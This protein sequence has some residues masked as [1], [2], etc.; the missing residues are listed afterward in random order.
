MSD[1][2]EIQ[3]SVVTK[4]Q[5]DFWPV[6]VHLVDGRAL[7]GRRVDV[8]PTLPG[9]IVLEGE[10]TFDTEKYF[11]VPYPQRAIIAITERRVDINLRHVVLIDEGIS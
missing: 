4:S 7:I 9:W 2:K 6:R 8:H 10:P 11:N 3:E 5:Q 1:G